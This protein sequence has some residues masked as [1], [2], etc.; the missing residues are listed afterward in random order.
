[1]C[2]WNKSNSAMSTKMP[3]IKNLISI[4]RPHLLGI[5]EVNFDTNI[6]D[7]S[8]I[9]ISDYMLYLGPKSSNGII[10]LAV[11]IHKDVKV[12]LRKD[13]ISPEFNALWFEAN[14]P[15][16]KR[17]SVSQVYREWQCLGLADSDSVQEQFIRWVKYLDQWETALSSGL[18]VVCMGDYNLNHC[19]WTDPNISHTCQTYKLRSLISALFHRIVPL[20]VSQLVTDF[21]LDKTHLA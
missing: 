16:Q 11:Y 19:N 13:L 14:L 15:N 7:Q 3:E 21:F 20:G 1:M 17:I 4:H 5:S 10:R 12:K 2:H 9:S 8:S 6:H 18:E